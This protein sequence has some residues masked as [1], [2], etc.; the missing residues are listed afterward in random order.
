MCINFRK[1]FLA[2]TLLN[3][4][5]HANDCECVAT[6]ACGKTCQQLARGS[7]DSV[8]SSSSFVQLQ[9]GMPF[10]FLKNTNSD[11]SKH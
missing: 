4:N 5:A 10:Y 8:G 3:A 9:S 7:L 2:A 6:K 1:W 11:F